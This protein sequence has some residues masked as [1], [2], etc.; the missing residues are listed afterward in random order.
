MVTHGPALDR[1]AQ[2]YEANPEDRRDRIF[3]DRLRRSLYRLPDLFEAR[4]GENIF[5]QG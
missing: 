5:Y 2:S 1:L 3:T 4:T